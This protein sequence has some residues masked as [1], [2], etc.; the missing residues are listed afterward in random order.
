MTAENEETVDIYDG[1]NLDSAGDHALAIGK[2]LREP[3]PQ[4]EQQEMDLG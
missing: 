4:P 1:K 2:E 3:Q